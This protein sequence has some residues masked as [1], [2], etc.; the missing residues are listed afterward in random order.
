LARIGYAGPVGG[1]E[2]GS[3]FELHIEQGPILDRRETPVGIVI[4]G[5]AV[6]GMLVDV[7]GEAAHTGPTPTPERKNALVG[8]A[9]VIAV[10]DDLGWGFV[11]SDGKVTAA[12]LTVSPN[13]AGIL[14]DR[15]ELT[16]DLLHPDPATANA[17]LG[18]VGKTPRPGR[19]MIA[20][21]W[22]TG[23][24]AMSAS[25][26]NSCNACAMLQPR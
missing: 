10:G 14:S 3:Y 24:L 18:R 1:R 26:P 5:Y 4:G 23:P 13:L 2:V 22:K 8:A 20:S 25:A 12:R 15:S 7:R 21:D 16:L 9:R 17:M 11:V 19:P 6:R